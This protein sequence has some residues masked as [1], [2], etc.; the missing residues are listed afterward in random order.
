MILKAVVPLLKILKLPRQASVAA[1]YQIQYPYV[2]LPFSGIKRY[3]NNFRVLSESQGFVSAG[4]LL[5]LFSLLAPVCTAGSV[6]KN[7]QSHLAEASV[8]QNQ[9]ADELASSSYTDSRSH[10]CCTDFRAQTN[11]LSATLLS[12]SATENPLDVD[13][14]SPAPDVP[15]RTSFPVDRLTYS[16]DFYFK[17]SSL[18][19]YLVTQ[20]LRV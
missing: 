18:P 2:K 1:R 20:R 7:N 14:V 6:D 15:A 9:H 3:M 4:I 5:F 11:R 19:L 13:V 16:H 10:H 17:A 12:F 8:H